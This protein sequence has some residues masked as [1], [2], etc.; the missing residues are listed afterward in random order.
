[1]AKRK[2]QKGGASTASPIPSNVTPIRPDVKPRKKNRTSDQLT[3][4][5]RDS[6][7]ELEMIGRAELTAKARGRLPCNNLR[8]VVG[9]G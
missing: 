2:H 4:I 3:I 6:I 8:C 5:R 1:M 7:R 9:R